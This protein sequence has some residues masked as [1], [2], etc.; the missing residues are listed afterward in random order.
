MGTGTS[1]GIVWWVRARCTGY[2]LLAGARRREQMLRRL[3][4]TERLRWRHRLDATA[5]QRQGAEIYRR[6]K[7]DPALVAPEA[8][9]LC[10]RLAHLEAHL[11]Q[12]AR[13]I[14]APRPRRPA[15]RGMPVRRGAAVAVGA[16]G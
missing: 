3:G 14:E 10:R 7:W 13:G 5:L 6:F 1:R 4:K 16:A 15:D 12:V 2:R 9:A 8:H 11:S